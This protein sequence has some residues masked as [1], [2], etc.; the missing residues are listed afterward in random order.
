[1][2]NNEGGNRLEWRPV[3][4]NKALWIF[5]LFALVGAF[6]LLA[7]HRD[8]VL[9]ALPYLLLL[10]CPFVH[11]FMHGGHGHH[12]DSEPHGKGGPASINKGE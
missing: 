4:R 9:G 8:H 10:A 3:I 5:C 2:A 6:A 12:R 1:M 11:L 7:G